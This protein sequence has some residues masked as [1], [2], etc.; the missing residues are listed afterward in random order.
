MWHQYPEGYL[1]K[2]STRIM[3]R[4]T[5]A[6]KN[7]AVEAPAVSMLHRPYASARNPPAMVLE[8]SYYTVDPRT[9]ARYVL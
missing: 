4:R 5:D 3:A 7:G 9:S 1:L 2:L 6:D 8:T